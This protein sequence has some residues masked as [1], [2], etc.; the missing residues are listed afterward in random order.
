MTT[1]LIHDQSIGP[2]SLVVAPEVDFGVAAGDYARHRQGHPSE[3]FRRLRALG[4]GSPGQALV[5][6]GTGTGD[7]A[8]TFAAAGAQ[9]VGLD[10]STSLLAVAARLATQ[11]GVTVDWRHGNAEHTG[12]IAA[13]A[14]A[15]TVAQAWH[16]FDR[17]RALA[18]ARRVLRPDGAL[19]IFY[20]DWLPL[21]ASVVEVTLAI[22]ARHRTTPMPAATLLGHHGMYPEFADDLS[23]ADFRDLQIFGFDLVQ[24]YAHAGWLGRMRASAAVSTMS[25]AGQVA[26]AAELTAALRDQFTDPMPVPHRVFGLVGRVAR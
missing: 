15:I 2:G 19:A 3:T 4:I 9:V 20:V 5:D 8:R 25:A 17:P 16:W 1:T 23:G 21:P 12:L 14:D 13:S 18:E 7:A 26:F 10:P 22:V 6:L 11:Q 24:S